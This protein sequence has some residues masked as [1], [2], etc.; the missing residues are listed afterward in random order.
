MKK[1]KN[2]SR[3]T[4]VATQNHTAKPSGFSVKESCTIKEAAEMLGVKYQTAQNLVRK[5]T[6][7]SFS[8]GRG[9]CP[10]V[11]LSSVRTLQQKAAC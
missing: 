9:M 2:E 10:R 3:A 1:Q 5:G 4:T 8:Y 6:L 7:K 11:I